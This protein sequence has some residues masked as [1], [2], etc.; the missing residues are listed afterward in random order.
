[1]D[2]S[3]T[4]SSRTA[5][6][7]WRIGRRILGGLSENTRMVGLP[8]GA[9]LMTGV[10]AG[11]FLPA[12]D[13]P[14]PGNFPIPGNFPTAAVL[15]GV[16]STLAFLAGL[17]PPAVLSSVLESVLAV[18][19]AAIFFTGN[20]DSAA[21]SRCRYFFSYKERVLGRIGPALKPAHANPQAAVRPGQR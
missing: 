11:G 9:F 14:M 4:S 6:E 7:G 2:L 13:F 3:S 5:V 20:D 15:V 21:A 8:A 12:G 10:T 16:F 18:V 19:L 17:F 1:M